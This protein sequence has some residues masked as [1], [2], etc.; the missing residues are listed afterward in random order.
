MGSLSRLADNF[1]NGRGMRDM[2]TLASTCND[3]N[4]IKDFMVQFMREQ[5]ISE[6]FITFI[7]GLKEYQQLLAT[8]KRPEFKP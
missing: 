8:G 6:K 5:G 2:R 3:P 4:L 1:E 7:N